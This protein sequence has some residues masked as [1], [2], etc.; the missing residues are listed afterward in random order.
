MDFM[1]GPTELW[2]N[3]KAESKLSYA[4]A[5]HTWEGGREVER[6]KDRCYP[7]S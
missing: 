3:I 5:I 4:Q 6:D 1:P 7:G 2:L